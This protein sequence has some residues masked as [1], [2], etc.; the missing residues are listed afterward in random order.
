MTCIDLNVICDEK[1]LLRCEGRLKNA[2]IPYQAKAP[3]LINSESYLATLIVNDICTRFKQ[4][5]IKQTLIKLRQNFW[6]CR[7][8]QFVR[9]I[10]RK[11]VIFKKYKGPSY[12]YP[13]SLPFSELRIDNEFAFYAT[14]LDNFGELFVRSLFTKD[15]ST[16]F[17]V[18]VNLYCTT[19]VLY[20]ILIQ[21]CS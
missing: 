18:W 14:G 21:P 4:I 7:G 16:L 13:V 15:S 9:N 2:L 12:Q 10:I 1:D 6:I 3:Y 19:Y 5:S 20:H 17:K 8:K 11:S